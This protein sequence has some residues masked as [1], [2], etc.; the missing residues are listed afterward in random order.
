MDEQ[1]ISS[2][3]IEVA[4]EVLTTIARLTA[5]RVEGVSRLTS[6]PSE[7]THLFRRSTRQ[8][9]V[10]LHWSE[11][12][13]SFD[14]YTVMEPHVNLVET[15]RNLQRAIIEAIDTMVGIPVTSVNVHVEDVVYAREQ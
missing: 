7:V 4:P 15:S 1:N 12:S 13:L 10:V 3:R 6:A 5:I 11:D 14:V 8:E 9:G 2:G